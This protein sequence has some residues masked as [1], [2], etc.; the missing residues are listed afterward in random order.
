[1]SPYIY[2]CIHSIPFLVA[3]FILSSLLFFPWAFQA[4]V[5]SSS[6]G[7]PATGPSTSA[8]AAVA[9]P[10][11]AEVLEKRVA[12][13]AY[14]ATDDDELTFVKGDI[15]EVLPFPDPEEQV[16]VYVCAAERER[17]RKR[18]KERE[19][20]REGGRERKREKE[21]E[22]KI[23]LYANMHMCFCVGVFCTKGSHAC[24]QVWFKSCSDIQLVCE[25][26]PSFLFKH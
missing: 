10:P 24:F 20:E 15:I 23:Y 1:M 12:T 21:R 3:L 11:P 18:K 17:E 9:P 19:G 5:S 2:S 22:R 7:P 13:H 26:A 4:A 25:R 16:C 14:D 8:V 6:E